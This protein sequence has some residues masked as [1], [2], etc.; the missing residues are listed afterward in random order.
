MRTSTFAFEGHDALQF[1]AAAADE[2]EVPSLRDALQPLD[3]PQRV[4]PQ[5]IPATIRGQER[6]QRSPSWDESQ[7]GVA[8]WATRLTELV[9]SPLVGLPC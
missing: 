9:T 6:S 1:P 3:M 8:F 5:S 7:S 2:V 4:M